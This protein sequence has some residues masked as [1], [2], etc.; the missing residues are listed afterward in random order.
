MMRRLG[1]RTAAAP[2]SR[3]SRRYLLRHRGQNADVAVVPSRIA[4]GVP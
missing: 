4:G 1:W 3:A 2:L